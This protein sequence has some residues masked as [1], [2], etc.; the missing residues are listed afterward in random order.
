M[1]NKSTITNH[2]EKRTRER[3]VKVKDLPGFIDKIIERGI[4]RR[5]LN[6]SI[7]R[8]IDKLYLSFE[9]VGS[10]IRIHGNKIYIL[11]KDYVLIT[12]INLP[13][14]Y[15]KVAAQISASKKLTP[16]EDSDNEN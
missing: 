1:K 16:Q 11:N 13:T 4:R 8:Y 14:K 3:V 6:G 5:E 12:V 7:R 2:G 9:K 10:N 15:H